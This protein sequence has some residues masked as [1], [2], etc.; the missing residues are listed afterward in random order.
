MNFTTILIVYGILF[1]GELGDKTQLIVFNLALEHS[2]F[3]KVGIG[4]TLGFV[5]LVTIGVFFGTVITKFVPIFVI[6]IISGAIFIVI[7]I[8]EAFNLKKAYLE[9]KS[10][11]MGITDH[12]VKKDLRKGSNELDI[13][14]SKLK[15][16]PY[17]AGFIYIF[18]MELG[19]KTQLLTISLA[20]IYNTPLEVWIGSFLALI[21][22]AWMGI[23]LGAVI[24]R[25]VSKF[26]LKII[27]T[28]IFIVVGVLILITSI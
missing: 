13:K 21:T 1:V 15:S 10:S 23:L 11:K 19:D 7:G 5:F 27:S 6:S 16:N 14:V 26:Y 20:S 28:S 25:K 4:V 9:R 12:T 8:I 2:K 18:L 22:V 3:Y 17:L 24:A